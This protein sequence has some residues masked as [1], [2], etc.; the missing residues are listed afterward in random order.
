MFLHRDWFKGIV[1]KE[2]ST[3]QVLSGLA[4][5]SLFL[6]FGHGGTEKYVTGPELANTSSSNSGRLP[7]VLLFG[8][9]SG[10]LKPCGNFDPRGIALEY[11]IAGS[12]A[13]LGNLWDVTDVDIDRYAKDL[14]ERSGVFGD[15][16]PVD[17]MAAAAK[18]RDICQLPY[19]V[20][21]APVVY[22]LPVVISK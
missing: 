16:D 14:L 20:G 12:P 8:C 4:N 2:P 11:L 18:S 21:A 3:A 22:G 5:S 19:L 13:V 9:S 6:Y 1:G 15:S 10:F 17:L 7:P